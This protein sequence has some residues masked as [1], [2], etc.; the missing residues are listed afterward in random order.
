MTSTVVL[1]SIAAIVLG[2]TTAHAAA[3]LV[4]LVV[5]VVMETD[6]IVVVIVALTATLVHV[7]ALVQVHLAAA[8]LSFDMTLQLNEHVKADQE[9]GE[10]K[11]S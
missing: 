8:V 2:S 9:Q 5:T 11:E 3:A 1:Y 10:M 4:A 6:L 7:V